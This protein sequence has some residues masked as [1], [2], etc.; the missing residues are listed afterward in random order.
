M[1]KKGIKGKDA[2]MKAYS[3][4]VFDIDGTLIDTVKIHMISLERTL[5]KYWGADAKLPDLRFSF[6]I[7]GTATMETLKFAD[8]AEAHRE[9]EKEY[10][11]CAKEAPGQLFPGMKETLEKLKGTKTAMGIITSKTR[12]EYEED[13]RGRGLGEYFTCVVTSTDTER[14]KP[15][16]EPM[17]EYLKQT[18]AKPGEVL[19]LGDSVHDM[20]CARAAG[21][22]HAL[23]LW[24]SLM[25]EGI[26][27]TYR[28]EKP[29]EILGFTL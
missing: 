7:P 6:G 2:F 20:A 4:L 24:G 3:H 10:L 14:G 12:S 9:W 16:P 5:K 21:V 8:P 23:V 19:Y 29:E 26:E 17:L 15:F 28:L 13:F 18:G 22:D 11:A 27:A 25:P 1:Q